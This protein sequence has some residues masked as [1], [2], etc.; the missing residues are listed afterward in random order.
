MEG[1]TQTALI[2]DE[3]YL[4]HKTGSSHHEAPERLATAM[5]AIKSYGL[6]DREKCRIIQPRQATVEEVTAIH[7]R[8]YVEDVKRFCSQGGGP[9]DVDTFLSPESYDV[10]LLAAG[11]ALKACELVYSGKASNAFAMVRPPGHHAGISGRTVGAASLGFCVFNNVAVATAYLLREKLAEK[12]AILD[13]DVHHGNGTQEIFN[14][15]S[16]VLYVSIH[17]WGIYPGTGSY[18]EIGE[19]EGKGYK[20]N[21]PLPHRSNDHVYLE[22]FKSI[23]T[24]IVEQFKPDMVLASV[25]YD[26]HQSDPIANILL[27]TNGYMEVFRQMLSLS[28]RLCGGKFVACLEGGYSSTALSKTLPATVAVMAGTSLDVEEQIYDVSAIPTTE[29][30]RIIERLRQ[31]LG[32]YWKF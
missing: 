19:G 14:S 31:A 1:R 26:A 5:N 23:V 6:L 18:T 24:P 25:G 21:I 16:K 27:T 29:A 30:R 8:E 3:R 10:A 28:E 15:T 12:V 9:Y 17:E 2:Y 20:V 13:I 22:L 4:L 11:G 32:G 7:D